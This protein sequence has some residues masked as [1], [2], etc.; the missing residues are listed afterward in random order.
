MLCCD[1]MHQSIAWPDL[2]TKAGAKDAGAFVDPSARPRDASG[3]PL[4]GSKWS[5]KVAAQ[6]K[7]RRP[8][9]TVVPHFQV[10][11]H[12]YVNGKRMRPTLEE[13]AAAAARNAATRVIV[14]TPVPPVSH[15]LWLALPDSDEFMVRARA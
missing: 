10:E 13:Q 14:K 4:L 11:A 9:P 2:Q 8:V 6:S 3:A 1:Q 15:T 7:K 5:Q 12:K